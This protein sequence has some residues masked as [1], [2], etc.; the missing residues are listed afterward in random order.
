MIKYPSIGQY[1]N[2]IQDITHHVTYV[3]R[4][5]NDEP[6]YD[7]S[8]EKPALQFT[9]TVK[10]HGT[11]AGVVLGAQNLWVQSRERIITPEDDNAGF[12]RFV[13]DRREVFTTLLQGIKDSIISAGDVCDQVVLFG[14]WAGR[15]INKGS[16]IHNIDKA[17][18]IFGL[19]VI[20]GGTRW[21]PID[22]ISSPEHRIY[23]I[24]DYGVY[25]I[26]IDFNDPR[27]S[28]EVLES[29]TLEV[30]KQCPVAKAFGVEGIGEG[31]VWYTNYDGHRYFFKVKGDEHKVAGSKEKVA[32]APENQGSIE[33]FVDYSVTANRF[34]QA[35]AAIFGASS[36]DIKKLGDIIKWMATDIIKEENDTLEASNLTWK[37]V[38]GAVAT[39]TRTMFLNLLTN[40]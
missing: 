35:I 38:Q 25:H 8:I 20:G 3:G 16:G 2:I 26:T 39:K 22:G 13:E 34:D 36:P 37:Q 17:F 18:F 11:N 15:G 6:I 33:E 14:E 7:P 9:G 28:Q 24:E 31:I 27:A 21:L 1:R 4:D 5:E 12:A 23:N 30:E 10:L 40:Y 29:L 32:V 19:Q